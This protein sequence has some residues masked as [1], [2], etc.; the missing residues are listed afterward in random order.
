MNRT[1]LALVAALAA[2]DATGANQATTDD[3]S[4]GSDVL[5]CDETEPGQRGYVYFADVPRDAVVSTYEIMGSGPIEN[6]TVQH[7]RMVDG[8]IRVGCEVA[9]RVYGLTWIAPGG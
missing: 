3:V 8:T 6:F 9:G 7:A 5:E 1:I 4:F 2:C